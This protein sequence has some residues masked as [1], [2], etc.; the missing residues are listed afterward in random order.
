[1]EPG[2]TRVVACVA[3]AIVAGLVV[4]TG[5]AGLVDS[6]PL[7]TISGIVAAGAM[8]VW[9]RRQPIED[10]AARAPSAIRL[11]FVA[12]TI[13]V[14]VQLAWLVPFV[15][16][17]NRSTWGPGPTAPLP[18]R[19]SCV[20]AYWVADAA[21]SRTPDVYAE[22]LSSVPQRDPTAPRVPRTIGPL[23]IDTFEYPPTF[24]LLPRFLARITP[25]FW[26][27][28]RLW[29]ALNFAIVIGV[30]IA[31]ALRLDRAV[32]THAVWLTPFVIAAPPIISTFQAGNVQMAIIAISALAMLFFERRSYTVGGLLLAYVIAGKLYPGVLVLY[33]LLRRDWR[34]LG[35]TAGFGA[36]IVAVSLVVFGWPPFAAFLHHVPTLLSG[37]A[38]SAF[39]N[40]FGISNNGSVPGLV[41]KLGL[42]G[43][44]HM[45]YAAMRLLGWAY[46]L[47]VI[48]A[49][50]WLA[51]R[52]HPRGRE[53][54]IWLAILVLATMRSPFL[55]T[56][57]AFPS[58]WL[59]T[60]VA[61]LA[62]RNARP[63]APVI[64]CWCVLAVGFGPGGIPPRWNAAWTT[65]QTAL[66]F[67]LLTVVMR[68]MS[69]VAFRRPPAPE[70]L[71]RPAGDPLLP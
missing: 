14:G 26:G 39:R 4:F 43:V 24:L 47:V 10:A 11:A 54:L 59:A 22:T 35:W 40:P 17:P 23:N 64:V 15:I 16:D 13:L 45:G 68:A 18:S 25:D 28:R 57:A 58:L 49:T 42:F 63:V 21:I 60:L 19:H 50:V 44:P 3:A 69:D 53:P 71:L 62:W 29:F 52:A 38:F 41:F 34:A 67:V 7:A 65:I 8:A 48:G 1:M 61:A 33:L 32:G 55:P 20:S 46:T 66:A 51:L 70:T 12:G 30:A 31:L 36:A 2:A 37:E 9:L 27:F 56:Y 6:M 5:A